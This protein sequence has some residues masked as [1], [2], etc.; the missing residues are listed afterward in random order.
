MTNPH[1]LGKNGNILF[2]CDGSA[3]LKI[4]NATNPKQLLN[5]VIKTYPGINAFDVIPLPNNLIMVG[6]SG[7]YQYDYS[8]I[9][10]ITLRSTI[11]AVPKIVF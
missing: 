5:N 8:N 11:K 7:L 3:G 4:F 6:D 2:V 9:L 10:N 1:G